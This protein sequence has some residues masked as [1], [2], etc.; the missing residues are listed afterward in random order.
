MIIQKKQPIHIILKEG[1]FMKNKSEK[2]YHFLSFACSVALAAYIILSLHHLTE[3]ASYMSGATYKFLVG[4]EFVLLIIVFIRIFWAFRK[5]REVGKGKNNKKSEEKQVS[6]LSYGSS[7]EK[8]ICAHPP[9]DRSGR[10][11]RPSSR[12]R[13]PRNICSAWRSRHRPLRSARGRP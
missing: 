13:R 4:A 3:S 1:N 5:L 10:K 11:P 6:G 9:P 7:F 12:R 8:I 2:I